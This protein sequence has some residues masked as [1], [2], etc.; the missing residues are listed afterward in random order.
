M[1]PEVLRSGRH[2]VDDDGTVGAVDDA[3]LEELAG[4]IGADEHHEAFVEVLDEDW[5]VERVEHVVV[6]DAVLAG[7][8]C[9]ERRN[10]EL[11]VSL[12][13]TRSQVDLC[14][15][16]DECRARLHYRATFHQER[17]A[18]GARKRCSC[19]AHASIWALNTPLSAASRRAD[20]GAHLG[21]QISGCDLSRVAQCVDAAAS[22]G[23]AARRRWSAWIWPT[24]TAGTAR[25][26]VADNPAS[27][28]RLATHVG[29]TRLT[30]SG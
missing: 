26:R 14:P 28:G 20:L 11:Q 25:T 13:S 18:I 5:M 23:G 2:G 10:H 3:D 12:P 4:G 9:D 6:V 24:S 17:S 7:A 22:T 16:R 8:R 19:D 1:S 21:P 27:S 30:S 15:I 29:R